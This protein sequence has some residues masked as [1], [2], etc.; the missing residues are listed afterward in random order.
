MRR[1][2]CFMA[3]AHQA[4]ILQRDPLVW[5]LTP[6]N[7]ALGET[8]FLLW[9]SV[10]VKLPGDSGSGS[11]TPCILSVRREMLLEQKRSLR[12]RGSAQ[13]I[14]DITA[15]R[16]QTLMFLVWL[17]SVIVKAGESL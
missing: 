6:N 4:A 8:G 5:I 7:H 14:L 9:F 10:I 13:Q 12:C 2:L 3:G 1:H 11:I 17:F 16:S 15:E